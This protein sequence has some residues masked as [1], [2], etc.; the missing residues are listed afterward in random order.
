MKN[1]FS[2]ILIILSIQ[3]IIVFSGSNLLA[4]NENNITI[5]GKVF[6]QKSNEPIEYATVVMFSKRD[7]MITGT[8]SLNNGIFI[9]EVPKQEFYLKIDFMG[10]E[11]LIVSDYE[12]KNNKVEFQK[13][14]LTPKTLKMD[15]VVV[16]AEKSQME[17]KLDKRVFNVGKDLTSA[18]GSALD[19]LN[20]VPSVNVDIEGTVSL[21]GNSNVQMLINGKPSVLTEGSSLGTITSEMIDKVEVVTNPSAKYD[22]EGTSGII[23]IILKKNE[24]SGLNGA[25]TINVGDPANHSLGLSMNKRTEKFNLFSQFGVGKRTFESEFNGT[26]IDRTND[27]PIT[28]YNEGEGEKNE[29]FYNVILGTDYH[30]NRWNVLTLSGHFAYEIEDETSDNNYFDTSGGKSERNEDTEATNP[31]YEFELS[32]KKSFEGNKDKSL[33]AAFT[34]SLFAKDKESK[35]TNSVNGSITELEKLNTDFSEAD[36]SFQADYVDPFNK[37]STIET[38]VK[39]LFNDLGND[40]SLQNF[41]NNNWVA[42]PEFEDNFKYD[43]HTAAAYF[44]FGYEP[45]KLGIKLGL[46]G[47]NT[48]Q[49][50]TSDKNDEITKSYFDLF[51]SAHTSF[52]INE[53][54]SLQMGYSKRI[55]RPR[56]RELIPVSFSAFRDQYNMSFG[57]PNLKPEY[58]DSF[59]LSAIQIWEGLSL[60]GSVFYRKT[61]NV[62]TDVITVVDNASTTT[63]ENIGEQDDIGFEI[64]GKTQPI[65]WMAILFD[66][67][68]SS[69]NRIGNYEDQDFDFNSSQ[70]SGRLTLKLKLPADIDIEFLT[71]Y[72]SEVEELQLTYESQLYSDFGIKKK[73]MNGRGIINFSVRDIFSSR[74]RIGEADTAKFYRYSKNQR[75]GRSIVLGFSYGFGKGDAM[76]FSGHKRF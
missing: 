45:D 2:R 64:N 47:E 16:R 31:K 18:G 34:G 40:Y 26:T 56:W 58:T 17:F 72:R 12:V 49:K 76:E 9:L 61:N 8:I 32:Y 6:D 46:R 7:S 51:P 36:Y 33:I 57:N 19:V 67:Y 44:S 38:G 35:F 43:Q 21:R 4:K 37:S 62:I 65:K 55:Q 60:N 75:N 41:E 3:I 15:E 54:L 24:T 63:V 30:I 22:A 27:N 20:N 73:I 5:T 66:S 29:Q 69:Y 10:Y 74:K 52:K 48:E 71:R 1:I 39:Y 25:V 14:Y 70:W 68:F 11:S 53:R 28:F 59:E 23:N 50:V 42:D 13:L